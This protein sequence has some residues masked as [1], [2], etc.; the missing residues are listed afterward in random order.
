MRVSLLPE[1][2]TACIAFAGVRATERNVD[3]GGSQRILL[4]KVSTHFLLRSRAEFR[5]MSALLLVRG[6]T[7]G[8]ASIA[9]L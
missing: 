2:A 6:F 5:Q 3:F 9:A 1:H 8:E 7:A 4:R